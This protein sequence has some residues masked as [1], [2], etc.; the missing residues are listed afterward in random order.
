MH[1][2]PENYKT[3]SNKEK[4]ENQTK[5]DCNFESKPTWQHFFSQYSGF[6]KSPEKAQSN[7]VLKSIPGPWTFAS[8]R[9][10]KSWINHKD[11]PASTRM[12]YDQRCTPICLAQY[13]HFEV[14]L[15]HMAGTSMYFPSKSEKGHRC[16]D[17][18]T[19][20]RK[21]LKDVKKLCHFPESINTP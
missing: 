15:L 21:C 1:V 2:S 20:G 19:Y 3:H 4:E 13:M 6:E 10:T 18:F 8:H 12:C 17:C 7:Q 9:P 14:K 16:L 5:T 11:L